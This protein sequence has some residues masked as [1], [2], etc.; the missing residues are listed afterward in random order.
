MKLA[1]NLEELKIDPDKIKHEPFKRRT[2]PYEN[3]HYETVK[4]FFN[5]ACELYPDEDCILEKI[6][7]RE[8]FNVTTY[9]EFQQQVKG[10]GTALLKVLNQKNKRVVIIGETQL[11]WYISYM[12]LLCCGIIAVPVDREL[13]DNE[14]ENVIKRARATTVIYSPKKADSIKKI[15]DQIPDVEYFVEMKSNKTLSEKDVS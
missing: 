1:E 7:K 3:T 13:P 10:L 5:R 11:D 4:E 12:S 14:L 6:D 2:E 9:K 15:R 8:P